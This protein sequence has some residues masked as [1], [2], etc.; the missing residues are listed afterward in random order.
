MFA[1][2]YFL[3]LISDY[4]DLVRGLLLLWIV[5]TWA[6]PVSYCFPVIQVILMW[7][8]LVPVTARCPKETYA[9]QLSGGVHRCAYGFRPTPI[10]ELWHRVLPR[11]RV[12]ASKSSSDI[13]FLSNMRA[14]LWLQAS[15]G[16]PQPRLPSA[17]LRRVMPQVPLILVHHDGG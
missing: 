4:V 13:G 9:A 5:Q 16:C 10:A 17:L 12:G 11:E 14:L 8:G 15:A 1:I 7:V 6:L 2:V 3:Q